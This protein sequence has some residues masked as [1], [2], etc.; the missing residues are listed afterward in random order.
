MLRYTIPTKSNDRKVNRTGSRLLVSYTHL[1]DVCKQNVDSILRTSN[2]NDNAKQKTISEAQLDLDRA[3]VLCKY[4]KKWRKLSRE[5]NSIEIN[6][7]QHIFAV[8]SFDFAQ[9]VH[10][11]LLAL[12]VLLI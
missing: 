12:L 2:S 3:Q 5:K 10:Y 8:I 9:Q 7:I 1:C 4:Y 6:R 11:P